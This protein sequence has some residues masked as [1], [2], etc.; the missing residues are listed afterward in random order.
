MDKLLDFKNLKICDLTHTLSSEI[1]HWSGGCGFQSR[2]ILDY[3]D[4]ADAVKFRVQKLDIFSGIGTHMDA[5]LHCIP[6]GKSI[7]EIS[8]EDLFAPCIVIDVT[9]KAHEKYSA[10]LD[11]VIDFEDQYGQIANGTF[12]ILRTGWEKHWQTPEKYHNNL[13]FPSFSK[14]AVE[15]LLLRNIIGIGID[16]LSPDRAE[17]GFPVHQLILGA[18]KYIIEN[19]ANLQSLPQIG[20]YIIALPIKIQEGTEAPIRCVG[21]ISK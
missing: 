8:L 4:C 3:I 18:G 21:L 13:S 6:C 15:M 14:E 2:V 9:G 20:A 19:M 5:P 12:A 1:P 11:D 7:A 16:T 17:D 10:T